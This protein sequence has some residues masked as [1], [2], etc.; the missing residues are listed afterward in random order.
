L[1][2][3]QNILIVNGEVFNLV[4]EKSGGILRRK[5]WLKEQARD[6]NNKSVREKIKRVLRR[7]TGVSTEKKENKIDRKN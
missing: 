4:V 6:A 7:K 2:F 1:G 5:L 3:R